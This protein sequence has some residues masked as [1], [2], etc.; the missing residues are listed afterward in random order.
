MSLGS[1]ARGVICVFGLLRCLDAG[2]LAD[3]AKVSIQPRAKAIPRPGVEANLRIDSSLVLIPLSVTDRLNRP[4]LGLDKSNFRIFE[5]NRERQVAHL[6][7][8]DTPLAVG[9]ILDTSASMTSKVGKARIA[10][11]Q[12]LTTA[13]RE[14]EFFLVEFS[15]SPRLAQPL[16]SNPADIESHLFSAAPKGRT[17]LF[18]AVALGLRELKRSS[19]PRKALVII[20]DGGDNASRYTEK[21]IRAMLGESNALLYALGVFETGAAR[22]SIDQLEAPG[23]LAGMAEASGGRMVTVEKLNEL[24]EMTQRIGVELHNRYVLAYAPADL[25]RDGKFRRIRI[26]VVAPGR[27]APLSVDGRGGYTAPER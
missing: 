5:R 27:Q 15:N 3:E 22:L 14:D 2:A 11:C 19:R 24:P 1:W 12:F 17:A 23:I 7:F 4:V 21:E 8:E 20:S 25:A 26:S 10:V 13:N 18:D 16:T 6:S 9:L